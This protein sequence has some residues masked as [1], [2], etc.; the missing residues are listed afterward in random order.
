MKRGL[1]KAIKER[2]VEEVMWHLLEQTLREYDR[3][4]EPTYGKAVVNTTITTLSNMEAA[5]RKKS[6]DEETSE[7]VGNAAD[8]VKKW[9][10]ANKS[11]KKT[12]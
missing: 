6:P 11:Q 9:L 10:S 5:R 8:Q 12:L 2:N 3:G 1:A 4:E 7:E